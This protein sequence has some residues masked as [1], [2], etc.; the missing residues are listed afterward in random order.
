MKSVMSMGF[1]GGE[2]WHAN[3][4]M[5]VPPGRESHFWN[6]VL[7]SLVVSNII[8]GDPWCLCKS[9]HVSWFILNSIDFWWFLMDS[10]CSHGSWLFEIK[11]Y[12]VSWCHMSSHFTK[13]PYISRFIL[14]R[15]DFWWF[16]VDFWC[17]H[18]RRVFRTLPSDRG[19][20]SSLNET[21]DKP[22]PGIM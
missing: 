3:F 13:Y 20:S 5:P 18:L 9:P 17:S 14:K 19:S 15:F 8:P 7:W 1:L 21:Q 4:L 22:S 11:F 12:E 2:F 16:L 10:G 6:H